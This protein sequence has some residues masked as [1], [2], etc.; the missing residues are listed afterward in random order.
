MPR[1]EGKN[2]T[3]VY[4]VVIR[5][6]LIDFELVLPSTG[7]GERLPAL[8]V[9]VVWFSADFELYFFTGALSVAR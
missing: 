2:G 8:V 9:C 4:D 1:I 6:Q 3:L 5:L 7:T